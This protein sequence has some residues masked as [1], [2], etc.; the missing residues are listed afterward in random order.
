VHQRP[1]STAI[2]AVWALLTWSGCAAFES[3][4]A[5]LRPLPTVRHPGALIFIADGA[6][7]F[8][9]TSRA[10]QQAVDDQKL[11]LTAEPFVWSHGY[12]RVLA[13]QLD[14]SYA[15]KKGL[16]L[17][18]RVKACHLAYPDTPIY[19]IGHSAG[20]AVVLAAAED[21]PPDSLER[22]VLLA[23]SVSEEYDVRPALRAARRSL[24][25][26]C[27]PTEDW[28]LRF[29]VCLT[30]LL[31][32]R[33]QGAAGSQGFQHFSGTPAEVG[34]YAKLHN[35]PW[36]PGVVWTGHE[37]GHFGYYQQAYLRAFVLPLLSVQN[38]AN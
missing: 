11:P 31:E 2:L 27:S 19:L 21:L 29:G 24:D 35:H 13:D 17:A 16:L 3:D 26:F 34:A 8:R 4:R 28:Y 14:E 1:A 32:G 37:G 9:A 5:A 38:S 6:G 22:I 25:V 15:R 36:G 18:E 7:D 12:L 10:I 23:P 33:L 30:W 20:S